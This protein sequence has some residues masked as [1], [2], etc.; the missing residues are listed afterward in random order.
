M[1]TTMIL[2]EEHL[3]HPRTPLETNMVTSLRAREDLR[4][5]LFK[6]CRVMLTHMMAIDVD[7]NLSRVWIW[8]LENDLHWMPPLDPTNALQKIE[9]AKQDDALS[10]LSNILGELKGMAT[11]MGSELDRQ[12]KDLNYLQDDRDELN[13]WVKGANQC[14]HRLIG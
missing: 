4:A 13:S 14:A 5:C 8:R 6:N 12:N 9:K 11:D 3:P 7:S 10:N 2:E 1:M